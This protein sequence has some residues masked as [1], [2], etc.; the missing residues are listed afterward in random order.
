MVHLKELSASARRDLNNSI[1]VKL[2]AGSSTR[3][4]ANELQVSQS[5]IA[6]IKKKDCLILKLVVEVDHKCLQ[7]H[8]RECASKLLR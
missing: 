2:E 8:R 5:Y 3:D 1:V 4:V 6:R 7:M